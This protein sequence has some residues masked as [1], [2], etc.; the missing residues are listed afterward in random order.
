MFRV[1]ELSWP[2]R[3]LGAAITTAVLA[4]PGQSVAE[5]PHGFQ[6][7]HHLFFSWR[8]NKQFAHHGFDGGHMRFGPRFAHGGS[9]GPRIINGSFNQSVST[10]VSSGDNI[11]IVLA[12][13]Q[14]GD[15]QSAATASGDLIY[16]EE[17]QC[18]PGQYCTL[19]LGRASKA[20]KII[21][22]NAS[23]SMLSCISG[24]CGPNSQPAVK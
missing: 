14:S 2:S 23:G 6:S 15:Q 5:V 8:H 20:P 16:L 7:G 18:Q 17:G 1:S 3:L 11:A 22:L 12:A 13:P 24:Q 19:R 4:L 9:F 21:T 10:S